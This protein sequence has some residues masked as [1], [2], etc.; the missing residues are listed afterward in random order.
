LKLKKHKGLVSALDISDDGLLGVS[1]SYDRRILLWNLVTGDA[2]RE[3]NVTSYVV[4]VALTSMGK[5]LAIN[6]LDGTLHLY[7]T[8]TGIIWRSE[9]MEGKHSGL[10]L[11]INSFVYEGAKEGN[12]HKM[13]S[14][15]QREKDK[16]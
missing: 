8:L 15:V 10:A 12:E 13:H 16:L 6:L 5:F 7:E 3:I 2:I 14:F 4:N 11:R 1:G 9:R